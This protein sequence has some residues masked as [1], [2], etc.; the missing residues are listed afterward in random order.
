MA[1]YELFAIKV[2]IEL[3]MSIKGWNICKGPK[4]LNVLVIRSKLDEWIRKIKS[5]MKK[6]TEWPLENKLRKTF[7]WTQQLQP[8]PQKLS[9]IQSITDLQLR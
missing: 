5:I 8:T 4:W 9:E 7:I 3:F 6:L 2:M 1:V